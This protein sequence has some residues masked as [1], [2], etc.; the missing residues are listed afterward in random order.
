MFADEP[1]LPDAAEPMILLTHLA[2]AR[3]TGPDTGAFLQAQLA[4]DISALPPGGSTFAAYCNPRGQVIGL[5][6]VGRDDDGWLL[7]AA[8]D[9]L[10]GITRR[11]KMFV[12]RSKVRFEPVQTGSVVGLLAGEVATGASLLLSPVPGLVYTLTEAATDA[13]LL[14]S[15][16]SEELLL[17]V[18]WLNAASTERFIPQMLGLE[19]IGAVSFSKGCYPG[20]EIIARTRYLGKLKRRPALVLIEAELDDLPGHDCVLDTGT[21][22][23]Q[24]VVVDHARP[25]PGQTLALVVAALERETAVQSFEAGGCRWP[26][27]GCQRGTAT[28]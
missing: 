17:G 8:A 28:G 25:G 16:R 7:V 27:A 6:L 13:A 4:A 18:C 12:L 22:T 14:S 1:T 23:L 2:A 11:L 9:L 10:D 3:L 26:A 24:G 15:W 20:Q 21:E 19:K 5:L